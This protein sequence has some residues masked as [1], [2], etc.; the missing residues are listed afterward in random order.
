AIVGLANRKNEKGDIAVAILYG[1]ASIIGFSSLG[2]FTDLVVWA[3]LSLIFTLLY[4]VTKVTR[5]GN[6]TTV[7]MAG[8]LGGHTFIDHTDIADNRLPWRDHPI[9][10]PFYLSTE[11]QIPRSGYQG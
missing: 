7:D 2:T 5:A 1:I 4:I 11:L 3:S 6:G 9:Q 8:F 10:I